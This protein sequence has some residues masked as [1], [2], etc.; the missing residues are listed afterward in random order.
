[1]SVGVPI[2]SQRDNQMAE[3]EAQL[4]QMEEEIVYE[5]EVVTSSNTSSDFSA[6]VNQARETY[7]RN[8]ENVVSQKEQ[9]YCIGANSMSM[10]NPYVSGSSTDTASEGETSFSA[11]LNNTPE[12][13][14]HKSLEVSL[15]QQLEVKQM[16][17]ALTRAIVSKNSNVQKRIINSTVAINDN[18]GNRG[19]AESSTVGEDIFQAALKSSGIVFPEQQFYANEEG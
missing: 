4:M 1:V 10:V 11:S 13:L 9:T 8:H 5:E 6:T 16:S 18:S 3:I 17:D 12:V 19:S 14:R 7:G 15:T 2:Q